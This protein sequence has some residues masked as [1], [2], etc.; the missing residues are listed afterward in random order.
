MI[1]TDLISSDTNN[2]P[3]NDPRADGG[4]YPTTTINVPAE[5]NVTCSAYGLIQPTVGKIRGFK[6]LFT[7]N[8]PMDENLETPL[9]LSQYLL[10]YSEKIEMNISWAPARL[11]DSSTHPLIDNPRTILSTDW[12]S[13]PAFLNGAIINT[14]SLPGDGAIWFRFKTDNQTTIF[15]ENDDPSG[16]IF[17]K[18]Y[19]AK[20]PGPHSDSDLKLSK[21][22]KITIYN[23][24]SIRFEWIDGNA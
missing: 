17:M 14:N 21:V 11:D 19:V 7:K 18:I 10:S 6:V 5:S 23:A 16:V 8:L 4:V 13:E 15:E 24:G 22:G 9:I 2:E 20:K 12:N 1:Y 3:V